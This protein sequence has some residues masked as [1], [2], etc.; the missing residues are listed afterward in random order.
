MYNPGFIRKILKT[1]F[2]GSFCVFLTLMQTKAK[3]MVINSQVITS[4][5]LGREV[6]ID[7]Y[8]PVNVRDLK[9]VSLLLINDGQDLPTMDFKRILTNL[10]AGDKI[11]PLLCAGIYCSEDRKNEY[12]TAQTLDYKGRGTKASQYHKFIFD[13]LLPF[14]GKMFS[15]LFFKEKS[16]C[17]FSLGA[18]SALDIVWNHPKQFTK[19]GLFS[20]SFWWRIVNQ[21]DSLFDEEKHRIMHQQIRNGGFYP[22]LK[23]FFETG[24]LDEVA[25][26]NNNGVI[27]AIDDTVS[28]IYELILKGYDKEK[29]IK[30]LEIKDGKHDVPTWGRAFPA[31]LEWGWGRD[32]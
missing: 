19:V 8:L 15:I 26:R 32:V 3:E 22:W 28:L 23:F 2:S 12:G 31:F 16:F 4:M 1:F 30:Y 14:T 27:D 6:K 13:E 20:G 24:T 9:E 17:G 18:L 5:H 10:Y 7:F 21:D 11:R 29:N 25:D